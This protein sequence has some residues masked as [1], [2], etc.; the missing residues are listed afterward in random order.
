LPVLNPGGTDRLASPATK[1][2][3]NME[4]ESGRVRREFVFF[5]RAHE[6]DSAAGA[7]VLIAGQDIGGTSFQTET[8]MNT[9]KELL[10]FSG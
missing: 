7:I 6:V 9:G 8:A 4:F 5:N 3:I 10:F 1:A 2:A